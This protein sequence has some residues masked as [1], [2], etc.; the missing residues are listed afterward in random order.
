ML[1][2]AMTSPT[3]WPISAALSGVLVR[4]WHVLLDPRQGRRG[5]R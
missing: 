4:R 3:F 5:G 2:R 1:C